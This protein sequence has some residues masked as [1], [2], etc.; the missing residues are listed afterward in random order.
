MLEKTIKHGNVDP[1]DAKKI[2]EAA[3]K[4]KLS[5]S[6]DDLIVGS[7]FAS[8]ILVTSTVLFVFASTL[9]IVDFSTSSYFV[10]NF[11]DCSNKKN[12]K[13]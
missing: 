3:K 2:L 7:I 4:N 6:V 10:V 1:I 11:L 12:R 9:V 8:T 13:S 5:T